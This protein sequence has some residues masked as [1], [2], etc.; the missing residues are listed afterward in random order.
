MPNFF[1]H[2]PYP[3]MPQN[4]MNHLSRNVVRIESRMI[5]KI[6]LYLPIAEFEMRNR[7]VPVV[8]GGLILY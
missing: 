8:S 4:N 7:L 1:V 5:I 6:A 2:L 3:L